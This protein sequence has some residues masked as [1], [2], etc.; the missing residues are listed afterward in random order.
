VDAIGTTNDDIAYGLALDAGANVC[1]AGST[2]LA[3]QTL[4]RRAG[5]DMHTNNPDPLHK[6]FPL[7]V[8]TMQRIYMAKPLNDAAMMFHYC[9]LTHSTTYI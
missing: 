8:M 4:T 3:V 6:Y 5:T 9:W 7:P 1:V 2:A